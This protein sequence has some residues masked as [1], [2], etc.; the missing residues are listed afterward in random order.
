MLMLTTNEPLMQVRPFLSVTFK[1]VKQ[2][3]QFAC[4]A[5]LGLHPWAHGPGRIVADMLCVSTL[6]FGDPVIQFVLVEA[7]DFLLHDL[8]AG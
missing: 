3:A 8:S 6:Q 7:R 2:F 4:P 5:L 1:A